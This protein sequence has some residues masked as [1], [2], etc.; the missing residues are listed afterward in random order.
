METNVYRSI[1]KNQLAKVGEIL[2]INIPKI[3]Y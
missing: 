2:D 1:Q 3:Y